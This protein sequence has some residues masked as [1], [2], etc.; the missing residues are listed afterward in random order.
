MNENIQINNNT[1]LWA[2]SLMNEDI[3]DD[4]DIMVWSEVLSLVTL[5]NYLKELVKSNNLD[6]TT[7]IIEK[8]E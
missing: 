4:I 7:S 2:Y 8:K 3:R 5:G 6:A 1:D